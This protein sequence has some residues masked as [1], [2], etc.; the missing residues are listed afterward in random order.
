MLVR[1]IRRQ[2]QE[3]RLELLGEKGDNMPS[4]LHF[5][6]CDAG[7]FVCEVSMEFVDASYNAFDGG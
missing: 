7:H 4:K 2:W 3:K 6:I 1:M 5:V